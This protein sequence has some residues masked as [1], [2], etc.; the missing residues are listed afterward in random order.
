MWYSRVSEV[1]IFLFPKN[2]DQD[3]KLSDVI[4]E[5]TATL[6]ARCNCSSDVQKGEFLCPMQDQ[7]FVIF[8]GQL[9]APLNTSAEYLLS[10]LDDW[11]AEGPRIK[12]TDATIN[13]KCRT[14][15][16]YA[17][18]CIQPAVT[19]TFILPMTTTL[20][21]SCPTQISSASE[22][23]YKLPAT[24]VG[25]FLIGALLMLAV[26]LLI[27]AGMFAYSECKERY[28]RWL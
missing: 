21:P 19:T 22:P 28:G 15:E 8:R 13:S 6:Y 16:T 5:I 7:D 9:F 18:T 23:S 12:I 17:D 20:M 10:K 11:V 24:A 14:F 4:D 2:A 26:V 25:C 3:T 27:R 1:E